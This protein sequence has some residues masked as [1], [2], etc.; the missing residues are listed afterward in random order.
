MENWIEVPFEDILTKLETGKRPRGG[1]RG[2]GSGVPSIGG[3]HLNSSGGFDFTNIK[4]IPI[5]F[6]ELMGKGFIE[7]NDVL[8]VKDG[9]TTGKVSFIDIKFPFDNAVIN[10]HVFKCKIYNELYPKFIFYF[11]FSGIG[12]KRILK[13]FKGSA[14]G[15]IN[16]S[17][18]AKTIVPLAPLPEQIAIVAKIEQ[19][20]SE[21]DNGISNLKKAQEQLKT[22]RQAVFKKAFEGELTRAWR[23]K[24]T[25]LQTAEELLEQI[26]AE[27]EKKAK[28]QGKKIKDVKSLTD[29]ELSELPRIPE[30]WQWGKLGNLALRIQIGPFG[31]QLH[32][33]DYQ[34]QGIPIINPKHIKKHV[35]IP[36]DFISSEKANSLPQYILQANDILLGRRGE[37]GRTAYISTKEE[38]YFCGTGSLFVRLPQAFNGKLYSLI[39]SE[40]RIVQYLEKYGSGTTM[41]NLNSTILNNLP[42][43]MIPIEE[44]HQIV[45][46]IESRL[47]VCDKVEETIEESLEKAEAL[48]QSILKKAFEGK[49]LTEAEV[50]ACRKAPDWEPAENL[51]ERIKEETGKAGKAKKKEVLA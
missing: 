47:S 15:G 8:I 23:A 20:F 31:S 32:K 38:G 16:T 7:K 27:R 17:F 14:Q 34:E 42:I 18:A 36:T 40:K 2:I 12:Q 13:N 33:H 35:I 48:R 22:F 45:Q 50:A 43:Q 28:I 9:A 49:L 10:E 51:L 39:L 46:E 19:L 26:K 1:V 29:Y 25:S 21:L 24:Q 6:A 37:M 44:Q 3:E 41:T 30:K 11:L 5:E 4:Y